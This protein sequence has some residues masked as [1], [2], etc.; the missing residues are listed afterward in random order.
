MR[1]W[2]ANFH[3]RGK[4]VGVRTAAAEQKIAQE[5]G[6]RRN[7]TRRDA[8]GLGREKRPVMWEGDGKRK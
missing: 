1:R 5:L 8:R 6:L 7:A 3:L 2:I 4:T